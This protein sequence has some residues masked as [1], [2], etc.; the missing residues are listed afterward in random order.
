MAKKAKEKYKEAAGLKDK[1]PTLMDCPVCHSFLSASDVNMEKGM[2]KC[3]HCNHVFSFEED[4][5]WDP[6]GLPTDTQPSGLEVLRLQSLLEIKLRHFSNQ[7]KGGF[8]FVFL[9]TILWNA[10][11]LPFLYTIISS[12]QIHFLLFISIHLIAGLSMLWNVLG[13]IFNESTVEVTSH[14]LKVITKPFAWFGRGNIEIPASDIAQLYVSRTKNRKKTPNSDSG[15]SLY[16]LTKK[17]KHHLLLSGLD[18]KTLHYIEKEIEHYLK[19]EDRK[20]A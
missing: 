17:G 1:D 12:G 11:L 20:V 13:T 10:A 6:F 14:S 5:Y 7:P 3:G 19:I 2:A 4:G 15:L 9:F 16:V 18:R 8:G